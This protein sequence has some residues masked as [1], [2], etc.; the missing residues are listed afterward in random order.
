MEENIK[1]YHLHKDD[2]SKLHFELNDAKS[3]VLKNEKHSSKPHRHSFYQLI[4]LKSKGRHYIDY[5]ILEHEENTLFFINKNQIHNFCLDSIND[6]YL[7]HFNDIF[8]ERFSS[9]LMHR[10]SYSIFNEIGKSYVSLSAADAT[11]L[12][13]ICSLIKSEIANKDH[14]QKEQVFS[15]VQTVLFQIERLKKKQNTFGVDT[16]KDHH[17]A[18]LFKKMIYEHIDTFLSLDEYCSKL[19]INLK[20]LTSISKEFLLNTPAN[21]IRQV[22]VLEAKR[23][24]ANQKVTSKEVTYA[25]GFDQPTYFTKYFKKETGLTPKQFQKSLL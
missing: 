1:K 24:L 17:T 16:N 22:K 10:F 9:D 8:L 20:Q 4:W 25:L 15:M 7:F 5:E 11:K 21:I 2:Y 12:E 23:M 6:G 18:F 3:Y 19:N 13:A 14:F